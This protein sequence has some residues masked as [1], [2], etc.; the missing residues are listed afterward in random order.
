MDD[1]DTTAPRRLGMLLIA[2]GLA[3]TLGSLSLGGDAYDTAVGLLMAI[4][5][6]FLHAGRAWALWSYGLLLLVVWGGALGEAGGQ[7]S[8]LLPRVALPTLLGAYL[9]SGAVRS[10]LS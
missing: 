1:A 7:V 4:S 6:F 5:G 3:L 9:Y 8:A 10:R 2:F